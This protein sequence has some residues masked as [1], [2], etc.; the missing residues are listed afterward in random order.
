MRGTLLVSSILSLKKR[1]HFEAYQ[2]L[3]SSKRKAEVLDTIGPIWIPVDV[4]MAHYRA[5]DGL[6]LDATEI[7]AMGASVAE[8]IQGS[9]L[10]SVLRTVRE[11]GVTPL[12]VLGKLDR[13]FDRTFQ[14][15]GGA[16]VLQTGPKDARATLRGL[17]MA[18]MAYFR[19]AY[20][21]VFETG[22]GLFARKLY[23]RV[24]HL[25]LTLDLSF[26][27]SWA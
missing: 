1:G 24:T 17:P 18:E 25:P 21:G 5:C 19:S 9:F 3:L 22:L 26:D 15:G 8:S 2:A 11:G 12:V 16:Q 23:A 10:H 14:G 4:A 13:L 20:V 27:L 6:G 7:R